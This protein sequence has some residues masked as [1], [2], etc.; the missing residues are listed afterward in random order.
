M[1]STVNSRSCLLSINLKL[2]PF[3]NIPFSGCLSLHADKTTHSQGR[4][5]YV[6][7]VVGILGFR[8]GKAARTKGTA[9]PTKREVG[10]HHIGY[11]SRRVYHRIVGKLLRLDR[12]GMIGD[13]I[14]QNFLGRESS[15]PW[16][17]K[18]S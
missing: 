11:D 14:A 3:G 16:A 6:S 9:S 13:M 4:K 17:T 15:P 12:Y 1:C 5:P 18:P 2:W 10:I 7:E 8:N